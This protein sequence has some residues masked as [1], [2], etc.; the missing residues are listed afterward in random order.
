MPEI[1]NFDDA[2]DNRKPVYTREGNVI[3]QLDFEEYEHR[4]NQQ[5]V[6]DVQRRYRPGFAESSSDVHFS[7]SG[8]ICLTVY[9][10]LYRIDFCQPTSLD[11]AC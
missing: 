2:L 3:P 6:E 5:S 9:V 10:Q 7:T 1:L 8:Q 4:K 11:R